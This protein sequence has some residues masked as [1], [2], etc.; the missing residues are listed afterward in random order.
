M[1]AITLNA[2]MGAANLETGEVYQVDLTSEVAVVQ[3]PTSLAE[4]D[5]PEQIR[6]IFIPFIAH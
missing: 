1:E 3:T 2:E 6:H 4:T 5:E